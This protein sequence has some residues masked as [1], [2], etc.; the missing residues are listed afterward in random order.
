MIEFVV[1]LLDV[2]AGAIVILNHIAHRIVGK[3]FRLE[4]VRVV[5]GDNAIQ[6]VER[7]GGEISQPVAHFRAVIVAIV[8][9]GG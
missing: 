9:V 8:F 6:F 5:D 7:V 3:R 2:T 4:A 1:S